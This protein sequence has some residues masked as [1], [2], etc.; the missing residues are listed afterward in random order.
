VHI[1]P[2]Y[3]GSKVSKLKLTTEVDQAVNSYTVY[4]EQFLYNSLE[5]IQLK[6][7]QK[8]GNFLSRIS[9]NW[10]IASIPVILIGVHTAGT[11]YGK[12]LSDTQNIELKSQNRMLKDSL[13]RRPLAPFQKANDVPQ[14]LGKDTT[15]TNN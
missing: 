3:A 4:V 2:Y 12:N 15:R 14:S 5:T 6:G 13:S 8:E 11:L 9:D 1:V 7:L 10:L